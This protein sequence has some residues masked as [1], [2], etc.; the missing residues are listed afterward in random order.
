M[1]VI[2]CFM[3]WNEIEV[4]YMRLDILYEFVDYF[5]ICESKISHSGK[6]TKDE[7]V[8]NKHKDLFSK[9]S[10]KIIFLPFNNYCGK[11]DTAV[12]G[13]TEWT[14]EN[15]QR[16]WLFNEIKK[17]DSN[18][19]IAISDVDEIWDPKNLESIIQM[20]NKYK[21]CGIIQKLTYYYVNCLKEQ[22]WKGTYF[23]KNKNLTKEKIQTL[24][25]NRCGL[26]IYI[27]GGWHFSWLGNKD[28]II[29]KFQCIAEHDI[30]DQHATEENIKDCLENVKDLFGRD[31]YYGHIKIITLDNNQFQFPLKIKE[32][33]AK[34][35]QIYYD[36]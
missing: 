19:L 27:K 3:F 17:F 23:I 15:S 32:Y 24:R 12:N 16:K 9:F 8:F 11:G 20:V 25:N 35:P 2:D 28:K 13:N 4:L 30:I 33:I 36:K 34:F 21:V 31:G 6:V 14:N 1:V 5:I 26:P 29:E 18:S 10:D 7:Y 22:E